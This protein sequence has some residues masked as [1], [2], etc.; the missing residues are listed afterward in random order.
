MS[1]EL[2][3]VIADTVSDSLLAP[4]EGGGTASGHALNNRRAAGKTGTTNDNAATWFSGYTPQYAT[5]VWIG[6]PRGGNRYPVRNITAYGRSYGTVF[7]GTVAAPIWNDLMNEI[8]KGVSPTWFPKP[9]KFSVTTTSRSVPHI[10]GMGVNEAVTL[11][12]EGGFSIKFTE[13]NSK[14]LKGI[15]AKNVVA[16]QSPQSG[17]RAVSGDVVTLTLTAGS[18]VFEHIPSTIEDMTNREVK[19]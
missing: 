10:E 16:K 9:E 12:L 17:G 18:D 4:F 3:P 19:R 5:S 7:G 14:A 15:T 8:H 6:D 2:N 1:A 13:E 11:L